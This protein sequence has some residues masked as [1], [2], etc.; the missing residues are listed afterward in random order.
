MLRPDIAG[1]RGSNS[2][3]HTTT[4]MREYRV[5]PPAGGAPGGP[6]VGASGNYTIWLHLLQEKRNIYYSP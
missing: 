4:A 5:H 6:A 1:L 3:G 2:Y